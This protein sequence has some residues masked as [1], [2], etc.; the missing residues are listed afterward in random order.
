MPAILS[1]NICVT[2]QSEHQPTIVAYYSLM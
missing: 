2:W 1:V